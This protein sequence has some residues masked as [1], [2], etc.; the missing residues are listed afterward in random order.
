MTSANWLETNY[1]AVEC[2][3]KLDFL[4]SSKLLHFVAFFLYG[5]P[6]TVEGSGE[7]FVFS[8]SCMDKMDGLMVSRFHTLR[9]FRHDGT[10]SCAS[11]RLRNI[12]NE[13]GAY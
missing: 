10:N 8:V 12:K 7:T 1:S 6:N 13:V 3:E 2:R 11:C 5:G 9:L 4:I